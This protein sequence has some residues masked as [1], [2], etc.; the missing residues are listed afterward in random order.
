MQG[1][2]MK[3][4]MWRNNWPSGW[5]LKAPLEIPQTGEMPFEPVILADNKPV[6]SQKGS[7]EGVV[8]MQ[9]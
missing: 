3:S 5:G 9:S 1:T 6:V 7:V 8:K 2:T 4:Q